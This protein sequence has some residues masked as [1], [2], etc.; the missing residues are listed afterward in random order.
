MK[1]MGR[2]GDPERRCCKALVLSGTVLGDGH[3]KKG[4]GMGRLETVPSEYAGNSSENPAFRPQ[5]SACGGQRS[6]H[7]AKILGLQWHFN[8]EGSPRLLKAL[9]PAP[10]ARYTAL[11]CGGLHT[12]AR[13]W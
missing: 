2:T 13:T 1:Q 12:L 6:G 11:T 10:A 7:Q 3:I 5:R 9:L 8:T 4:T